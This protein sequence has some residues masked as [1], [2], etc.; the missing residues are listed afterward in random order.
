MD[1]LE[2]L[3]YVDHSILEA[4]T[5]W[6]QVEKVCEEGM[7]YEVASVC[8]PPRY[9]GR[10][11]KLIL[12]KIKICTV[13]GFP[14][15]Y[16]NPETKIFETEDAIRNGADEIDLMMNVGLAKSGDWEGILTE[17]K[18]VKRSCGGRILKVIVEAS[19][20]TEAEKISA[21]RAVSISGAD[22]IKTSSGFASG[23]A[24]VE[25]VKLFRKHCSPDLKIKASGGIGTWKKAKEL[26]E[27]GA[28]RLGSSKLV[29]LAEKSK[30]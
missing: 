12:K 11:N 22:Y 8:I 24:T 2:L 20:L 10:A 9:V 4:N 7:K 13:I 26:L 15:G 19:E 3:H 16:S 27:A 5:T 23:G 14:F 30:K 28:D 18:E 17:F 1:N 21:C 29:G 25:D 6:E